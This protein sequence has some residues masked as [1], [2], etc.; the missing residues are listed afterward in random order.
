MFVTD[1]AA[2]DLAPVSKTGAITSS[3]GTMTRTAAAS[4]PATGRTSQRSSVGPL[5]QA[6]RSG[7][8][9]PPDDGRISKQYRSRPSP[10]HQPPHCGD[11]SSK[12]HAQARPTQPRR[13]D[14]LCLEKRHSTQRLKHPAPLLVEKFVP[15]LHSFTC[16]NPDR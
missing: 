6:Y 8:G 11:S 10:L 15:K 3:I 13:A 1:R 4:T 7:A 5:R 12:C 14:S 9:D 2:N 16:L